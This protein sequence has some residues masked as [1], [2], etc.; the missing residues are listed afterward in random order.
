MNL[1]FS[2][3]DVL[4]TKKNRRVNV[5]KF[6]TTWVSVGDANDYIIDYINHKKFCLILD[7]WTNNDI[8]PSAYECVIDNKTGF[9]L[10]VGSN[11]DYLIK[12]N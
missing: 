12:V 6:L 8:G 10:V 5:N 11:E 1:K 2:K 9:I 3:G 7:V 4:T